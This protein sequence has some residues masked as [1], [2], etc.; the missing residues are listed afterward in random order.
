MGDAAVMTAAE[1][2]G[3]VARTLPSF[4]TSSPRFL[5]SISDHDLALLLPILIYW[6]AS[7]AYHALDVIRPAWSEKYRLHA[8]E[9]LEKRNRVSMKRVIAMV[10]FQH[11]IQTALGIAIMEDTPAT[12]TRR[13]DADPFTDIPALVQTM[14]S[15]HLPLYDSVLVRAA[16]ALY[17]WGIPWLQFWFACFVLDAWQYMLH[18]TMHEVRF[19]YRTMHSHHHRLYVPYA[20]GA[21]YNHPLE[22]ML[23][24]TLG[25]EL[26]RV[27]SRMTLRQTMVFFTLSTFKTVC[28]H[29]GYAFPWYFNPIHA[30]F[31]NNAAYH[32]VHHQTQGLRYNYSQPFFVHFDTILGTRVDPEDFHAML[33]KKGLQTRKIA[34]A[35][36]DNE[37]EEENARPARLPVPKRSSPYSTATVWSSVLFMGI[38]AVPVLVYSVV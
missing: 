12:K 31:P 5:Q 16:I 24:D 15:L 28:D 32:D 26:A 4:Y 6:G 2:Q 10:A 8:P 27:V 23:L 25:A 3:L 29:G 19:L 20:F 7:L 18:R 1:V 36:N 17:W 14:R 35:K 22:G 34:S 13:L 30:L 37:A 38:L 21:L 33:E 11:A 9:E